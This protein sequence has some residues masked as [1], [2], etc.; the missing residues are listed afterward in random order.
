MAEGKKN[1]YKRREEKVGK[2]K[3]ETAEKMYDN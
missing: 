3:T 1:Y 2:G